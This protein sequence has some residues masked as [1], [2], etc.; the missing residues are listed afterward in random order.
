M[1]LPSRKSRQLSQG[2]LPEAGKGEYQ[3]LG[4]K[5]LGKVLVASKQH[6]PT[7]F[8]VKDFLRNPIFFGKGINLRHF[9]CSECTAGTVSCV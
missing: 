7:S 3:I 8:D 5:N 4:N 6:Y 9:F 2:I 1:R